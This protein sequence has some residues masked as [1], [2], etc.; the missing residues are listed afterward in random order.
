MSSQWYFRI[1]DEELGPISYP[2]LIDLVRSG[3]VCEGD[4][5]RQEWPADDWRRAESVVG[6]FYM[7]RRR[8]SAVAPVSSAAHQPVIDLDSTSL[9][10][11]AAPVVRT[12]SSW[13]A[14]KLFRR[15][16]KNPP[17]ASAVTT[18]RQVDCES[19][20]GAL[21]DDECTGTLD[22]DVGETPVS[23]GAFPNRELADQS[24]TSATEEWA[25]NVT[26]ALRD[27][28]ARDVML[29]REQERN[30]ARSRRRGAIPI[31]L[32]AIVHA[33][34]RPLVDLYDRVV[35]PGQAATRD[36]VAARLSVLES[37]LPKSGTFRFGFKFVA[38][39]LAANLAAVGVLQWSERQALRFPGDESSTMRSVPFVGDCGPAEFAF[40]VFQIALLAG[41]GTYGMVAVLEAKADD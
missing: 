18:T 6:L 1:V 30:E 34:S 5:V 7:A 23:V 27:A 40:V 37:W 20:S 9:N 8:G 28:R 15:L 32:A 41:A 13:R 33:V 39:L 24:A 12:G 36:R 3:T 17:T 26:E 31:L 2:E 29:A 25:T 22:R 16:L 14:A 35:Q 21:S 11:T 19:T 38:A 4:L 10:V